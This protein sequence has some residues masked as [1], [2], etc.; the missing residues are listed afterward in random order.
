[1]KN[2]FILL[3]SVTCYF[4]SSAQ[5]KTFVILGKVIDAESKQP[6]V[7]ASAYCQNTTQGTISN[8]EGLFFMRL[9]RGG[10]DMV[11]TYTGYE[12]KVLRISDNQPATDTLL[13]ELA[14]EDKSLSEVAVVASTA[15]PDGLAKYGKFF[16]QNFIGNS[17]YSGQCSIQ[18][19]EV[20]HFYYSKKRNRL[21][22]MAR[23]D[24]I[25]LNYALGYKIRYQLDSFSYD[26]NTNIT[27]YTGSPLFQEMDST[28]EVKTQWKKNRAHTYLGSRLHFMRSFYDSTLIQEG[29]IIE[30]LN[31]DDSSQSVK[32]KFITNPYNEQDYMVDS[33]DVEVGW[34]GRY[35]ISYGKVYPDKQF[36]EEYKLPPSTHYQITVLD[37]SDGFVIEEN[38]YFYEQYDVINSGY[39]AWKKLA[40]SLPYDYEYE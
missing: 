21:K 16:N 34:S 24:I 37:V 3:L 20:L 1:M 2:L 13:I 25:I 10:Y 35:R 4:N 31:D 27:Q 28:E 19:P 14:K 8:K 22:I 9:P 29:F 26:Y 23:E 6:L 12:K 7:G 11:V 40:E 38:G 5:E 30:K 17:G 15:D 36:L 33:G 18:N 32:G 39:W